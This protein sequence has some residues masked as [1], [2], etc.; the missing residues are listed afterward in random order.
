MRIVRNLAMLL[1]VTLCF[2]GPAWPQAGPSARQ[3]LDL[4]RA[5]LQQRNYTE[6]IRIFE[7]GAREHPD[8]QNLKLELG[9]AYLYNRQDEQAIRLFREVLRQDPSNHTAKLQLARALGYQRNYKASDETY[10]ELLI[11]DPSDEA[12]AIGLTRN[13]MHERRI[14]EARIVCSAALTRHPDNSTL[15][16]YQQKLKDATVRKHVV[17]SA[18]KEPNAAAESRTAEIQGSSGYF[19]DSAGNRSWRSTQQF[20]HQI[21]RNLTTRFR[22]EQRS[23]WLSGGPKANV[24][25]GSDELR[26]QLTHGLLASGTGG[27]VRFAD[28]GT[29]SL[30]RGEVQ[31]NPAKRLWLAGGFSRRPVSPTYDSAQF[32]LLAEGWYARLE[33]Y[34]G[35]WRVDAHWSREHYS[36][37]NRE[38]RLETQ[39]LRWIGNSRFAVGA[40]YRFNYL[41]FDQSLLH[42]YFNPSKYQSHLGRTGV[43]FRL[44]KAFRAEYLGGAGAESISAGPYQTAWELALR[45]RMKFENWEFSGDYFYF[46]LAQSTGAFKSQGGRL[47]VAYYF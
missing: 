6:A 22:A 36:D 34:P 2:S 16:E 1:V 31:L 12:A 44:G 21:T 33:W 10:R 41:A 27:V 9:G 40:G 38:K 32:N 45:N 35:A 28:G 47:A 14:D 19:A 20:D 39:I 25:W 18:S 13:L 7:D 42:G 8:D 37:S 15:Q 17:E 30:Y 29:R 24:L 11:S 26:M 3:A 4:G 23:L 46:R 43:R 5:A